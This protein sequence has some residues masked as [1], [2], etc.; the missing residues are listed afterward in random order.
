MSRHKGLGHKK[1]RFFAS[2]L[3]K[4]LIFGIQH[5]GKEQSRRHSLNFLA[6]LC[7]VCNCNADKRRLKNTDRYNTT[8][9]KHAQYSV[10][11]NHRNGPTDFGSEGW[12]SSSGGVQVPSCLMPVLCFSSP[13]SCPNHHAHQRPRLI[14]L[15]ERRP[16]QQ[17]PTRRP[18]LDRTPAASVRRFAPLGLPR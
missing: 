10:P 15:R 1:I 6:F 5:Y 12:C 2:F 7:S 17:N 4:G 8:R 18:N 11:E 9:N 14:A 16:P 13:L 3:K